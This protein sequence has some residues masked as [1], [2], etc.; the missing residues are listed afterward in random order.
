MILS[1]Y[2]GS[3]H[4]K[5]FGSLILLRQDFGANRLSIKS[6]ILRQTYCKIDY[7]QLYFNKNFVFTNLK[8]GVIYEKNFFGKSCKNK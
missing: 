5:C 7:G 6:D 2:K 4:S 3:K 1:N 8:R